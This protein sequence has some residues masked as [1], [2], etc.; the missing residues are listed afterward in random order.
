MDHQ[1]YVN[2]K[3]CSVSASCGDISLLHYLREELHLTGAK[4]GCG[5]G[6]CGACTVLIDDVPKRAC[7]TKLAKLDGKQILTI[8]GLA[9]GGKLHPVQQ[10]FLDAGAIQCGF[11]TPGLIL[12]VVAFLKQNPS[13]S[14][15]EIEK[16]LNR[17]I[18][19]CTGY[20]KIIEAVELASC[21]L[22]DPSLM[23]GNNQ[24]DEKKSLLK[25]TC[26]LES[27]SI[28]EEVGSTV[29]RPVDDR[30][31]GRSLWD[32]DG[33]KKA[34][35]ELAFAADLNL[36]GQLHGALV[37]AD[38]PHGVL[39][40]LD[41]SEAEQMP[42]VARIITAKDVPAHNGYGILKQDQ[43]IFCD[44]EIGFSHDVLAL[45]LADTEAHARAAAKAVKKDITPLPPVFSM[46]KAL[47]KGQIHKELGT[48]IGDPDTVKQEPGL[49][50]VSGRFTTPYQEHAC[51]ETECA[52]ANW[53]NETGLTIT[54][55]TQSI[56]EVRRV[57]A[58]V[59]G[60]AEE[61]ITVKAQPLGGGFGSKADLSIEAAAAVAAR[62]VRGPV[63][64]RINRMESLNLS[65]KR[66]PFRMDYT[67]GV[68]SEG[69][70]RF[71]EAEL[72]SDGG[73]Y[74]NLSPRVIDQACLFS[75]GPY[76]MH[77]GRVHGV[78]VK[79]NN[80]P[81]GAFRGFGINQANFAME[82]LIDEAAEKIGMDPFAIRLKNAFHV[83]DSTVSGEI[84]RSSVGIIE[85]LKL[86]KDAAKSAY[87]E[88]AP[89]YP[90]GN[91]VLGVG[92]ASCFKNVGA[93][94]GKVDDAG[95]IFTILPDGRIELRVSG[96][97]MGQ[98]FRTAMLQ[99]A[100]ETLGI[101]GEEFIEINGDTSCTHHH[102]N[103]VGERQTLINGSAV[104]ESGKRFN[105]QLRE[106]MHTTKERP[107]VGLTRE[108]RKQY[109]GET[110]SYHYA[111]PKT[112]PLDDVEAKRT[113]PPE[114]YRNYPGYAY[115]TQTAFIELDKET[116][117]VKVLKVI[118][119]H[120]CG[121]AINPHVIEG[122][123]EG[124]CSM[125]IGYALTEHIQVE[126]G[127]VT[128]RHMGELGLPKATETPEYVHLLFENPNPDGPFGAKGISEVAT[129]PM[130]PAITNAIYN[131][132][133]I[134]IREL[135]ASP[136]KILEALKDGV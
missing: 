110:F 72:L 64:L 19:R 119:A 53:S 31:I 63:K 49:T 74:L 130:T 35:G 84:L 24:K 16:A 94:K 112:Y 50:I 54:A 83:G 40:G 92:T 26:M 22:A 47:E 9:V 111:S 36:P 44:G 5:T 125:G 10:A 132:C 98:G 106:K 59:L 2:G 27:T 97:D 18:C 133:G 90:K 82:S 57:L 80:L 104:R 1:F 78:T 120:D 73:P 33:V 102:A 20:V 46:E 123:L 128:S 51:M 42:G 89:Q 12:T 60:E 95:A 127:Q 121:R 131:A 28:Y 107:L 6:Q 34:T 77:S 61:R 39:N 45:V 4:D 3:L 101:P 11:C 136:E 48:V 65:T 29:E 41:L 71:F 105:A 117:E 13:P 69:N 86:C 67:L 62:A 76:R 103:A 68:D 85:T 79:T 8:E 70:F 109:A 124:S 99:I 66:H 129:V 23:E 115:V 30:F 14:K 43:P 134:R 122:Q 88:L 52:I 96:V 81:C 135:P 113:L 126:N 118:A 32:A 17:N 21:Y 108:E 93:G 75:V 87:E 37:F 55:T 15:E 56:F 25:K 114:Q 38:I 100:S 58:R 116:G 7:I 91:K